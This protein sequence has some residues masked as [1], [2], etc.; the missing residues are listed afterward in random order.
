MNWQSLF[1]LA[2]CKSTFDLETS[3]LE[4]STQHRW[5]LTTCI[6]GIAGTV[7]LAA[8]VLGPLWPQRLSPYRH[9]R[10]FIHIR[11]KLLNNPRIQKQRAG[12]A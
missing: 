6:A 11:A 7:W 10:L 9:M 12:R 2:T 3:F 1:L 4:Q 8:L 5:L